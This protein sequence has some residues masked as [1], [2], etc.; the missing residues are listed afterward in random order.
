[1]TKLPFTLS[2]VLPPYDLNRAAIRTAESRRAEAGRKL[3]T[4]QA[5]VLSMVDQT[6]TGLG[7]ALAVRARAEGPDLRIARRTA[8][9]ADRSLSAGELDRTDLDAAEASAVE[10]E[11]SALDAEHQAALAQAELEDALH[12]PFDPAE[13][14]VLKAA[15]DRLRTTP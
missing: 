15:A 14:I 7:A 11:L 9:A 5:G 8:D 6:R 10:A 4:A 13:L 3:E 1:V 12:R 2:L